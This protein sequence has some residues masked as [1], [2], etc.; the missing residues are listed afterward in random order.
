MTKHSEEICAIC[1]EP[2]VEGDVQYRMAGAV[3]VLSPDGTEQ[4]GNPLDVGMTTLCSKCA[5]KHDESN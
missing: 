5:A 3:K 1:G 2:I 4:P